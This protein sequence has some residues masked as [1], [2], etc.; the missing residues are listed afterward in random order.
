MIEARMLELQQLKEGFE[1]NCE[2]VK[3]LFLQN[4]FLAHIAR[5]TAEISFFRKLKDELYG[6]DM[7]GEEGDDELATPQSGTTKKADEVNAIAD[8]NR[9]SRAIKRKPKK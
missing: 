3:H 2:E 5:L 8:L 9:L 1:R 4:R 6:P 7:Y